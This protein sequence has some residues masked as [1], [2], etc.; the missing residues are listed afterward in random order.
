MFNGFMKKN[1]IYVILG[2]M[3]LLQTSHIIYCFEV[4]KKDFHS[5]EIWSYGPANCYDMPF[6]YS[7]KPKDGVLN[8]YHEW[9]SGYE[10]DSYMTVREGQRFAYAAIY[11]NVSQDLHQPFY[12]WLLNTICSFFPNVFSWWFGFGL[13]LFFFIGS[14]ILLY[15]FI[16]KVTGNTFLAL[17]T[18]FIYGFNQGAVDNYIYIRMYSMITFLGL[19]TCYLHSMMW[20]DESRTKKVLPVICVVTIIGGLTHVYF[21]VF[22]FIVSACF[23]FYYLFRKKFKQLFLYAGA[24]LSAVAVSFLIYPYTITHSLLYT[25]A[26]SE[27]VAYG[28]FWFELRYLKNYIS[29]EL[30]GIELSVLP[31]YFWIYFAEV[32]IVAAAI[33]IPLAFLLRKEAWFWNGIRKMVNGCKWICQ[34]VRE[35][36]NL[37]IVTSGVTALFVICVTAMVSRIFAMGNS[38][39]RYVFH[40]YPYLFLIIILTAYGLACLL[41]EGVGRIA[42]KKKKTAYKAVKTLLV[43]LSCAAIIFSNIFSSK[44]FYFDYG[45]SIDFYLSDMPRKA[46]YILQVKD[47]NVWLLD[48][49]CNSLYGIENIFAVRKEE[50]PGYADEMNSLKSEAPVY[51][52]MEIPNLADVAG[53][54]EENNVMKLDEELAQMISG[55]FNIEDERVQKFIS[56]YREFYSS[57]D[58][59]D[60]FTYMGISEIFGRYV[61]VFRIRS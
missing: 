33:L 24:M 39:T 48:S 53:D 7:E 56:K 49:V 37:M 32:L 58:I 10:M 5:D 23:C 11:R 17:L 22:A 41:A 26:N 52:I 51:L 12:Y 3:I 16:K 40:I 18:C 61:F 42:E 4:K 20:S 30:T 15:L 14:Q 8:H 31:S 35:N 19:L 21:Y 43:V 60:E 27:T 57:L 54:D 2:I 55:T 9:I 25:D 59:S 36:V 46:N 34:K 29:Q 6:F 1:Y 50:I 13:N 47:I 44:E 45:D 38:A 28:G